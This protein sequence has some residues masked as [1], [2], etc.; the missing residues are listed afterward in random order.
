METGFQENLTVLCLSLTPAHAPSQY[1][2]P[3]TFLKNAWEI[4]Q[5]P[6]DLTLYQNEN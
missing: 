1:L 4:R 3:S 5:L 2:G 6:S